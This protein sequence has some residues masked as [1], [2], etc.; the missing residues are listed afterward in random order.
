MVKCDM[1]CPYNT[2]KGCRKK[3]LNNGICLMSNFR[4][5]PIQKTEWI[6]VKDRL[7]E[8]RAAVLVTMKGALP[9]VCRQD[10]NGDWWMIGQ[11]RNQRCRAEVTHW[12][13]LPEP[14]K[15]VE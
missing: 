13:P 11:Y 7:P 2:L 15:E 12:M 9:C 1:V 8:T 10:W 6:S 5:K 14:P 3:E 4:G